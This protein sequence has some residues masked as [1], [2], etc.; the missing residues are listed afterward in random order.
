LVKL[1]FFEFLFFS[2]C[3]TIQFYDLN[4]TNC[5][6]ARFIYTF[7]RVSVFLGKRERKGK[8]KKEKKEKEKQK[9]LLWECSLSRTAFDQNGLC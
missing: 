2:F 8:V 3:L 6:G 4:V 7:S 1:K 9:A 5:S